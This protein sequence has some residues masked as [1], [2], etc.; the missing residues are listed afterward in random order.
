[1]IRV[2]GCEMRKCTKSIAI[3]ICM[4][5][6]LLVPLIEYIFLIACSKG[7]ITQEGSEQLMD[8]FIKANGDQ[9]FVYFYKLLFHGGC[10]F[11]VTTVMAA[12]IVAED[13]AR[14]TMKY[15]M[16]LSS[17]L[18]L[19]LGKIG[20]LT[21][22]AS[23]LHFVGTLVAVLIA[24]TSRDGFY[25]QYTQEQL[26]HYVLIGWSTI[27][28]FALFVGVVGTLT[29]NVPATIGI[30]LGFYMIGAGFGTHLPKLIQKYLFLLNITQIGEANIGDMRFAVIISVV[31][32]VLLAGYLGFDL[33][34][35]EY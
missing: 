2:L 15:V 11:I 4:M 25:G 7:F 26:V 3:Y 27:I 13:Y 28:A 5:V 22:V 33:Q 24:K 23:V 18:K 29:K 1:M 19:G 20:I 10:V 16:L 9:L 17:R 12:I 34:R 14:G 8:A 21:I 31:S 30:G 6:M 32:M 35:K